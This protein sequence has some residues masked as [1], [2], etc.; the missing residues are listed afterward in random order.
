MQT[1]YYLSLNS[2]RQFRT[3][4]VIF[5]PPE[6]SILSRAEHYAVSINEVHPPKR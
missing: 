4:R 1:T 6:R 2:D 3:G 5:E